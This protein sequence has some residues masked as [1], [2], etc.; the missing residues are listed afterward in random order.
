MAFVEGVLLPTVRIVDAAESAVMGREPLVA[1]I[2]DTYPIVEPQY[3]ENNLELVWEKYALSSRSTLP[4]NGDNNKL[5]RTLVPDLIAFEDD[6]RIKYPS[7][8]IPLQLA[9]KF[10]SLL[11]KSEGPLNIERQ[12]EILYE[13]LRSDNLFENILLMTFFWRESARGK[14][15]SVDSLVQLTMQER[16]DL[17]TRASVI[18]DETEEQ[19]TLAEKG[20]KIYHYLEQVVA[21]IMFRSRIDSAINSGTYTGLVKAEILKAYTWIFRNAPDLTLILRGLVGHKQNCGLHRGVEAMG[22]GH[23]HFIYSLLNRPRAALVTDIKQK[24]R[25]PF[26]TRV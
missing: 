9:G 18:P 6:R 3:I 24:T 20:G 1:K 2:L 22:I 13:Q 23:G 5:T 4:V 19:H 25:A 15:K 16:V 26:G 10:V 17:L 21:T 14:E 8:I 7:D 12:L 11:K